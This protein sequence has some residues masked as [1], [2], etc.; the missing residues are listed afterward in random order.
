[1]EWF[2][3]VNLHLFKTPI[4]SV[5]IYVLGGANSVVMNFLP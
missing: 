1:M 3:S 4:G 2:R 5:V